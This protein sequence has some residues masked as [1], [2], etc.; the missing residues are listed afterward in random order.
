MEITVCNIIYLF[1]NTQIFHF[2]NDVF[3]TVIHLLM[4][5]VQHYLKLF[6]SENSASIVQILANYLKTLTESKN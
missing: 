1:L 6:I 4:K 2:I 3:Q 5:S